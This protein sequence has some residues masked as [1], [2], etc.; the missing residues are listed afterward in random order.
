MCLF[1]GCKGTFFFLIYN[2]LVE[3]K[4]VLLSQ[5]DNAYGK[6]GLYD[7]KSYSCSY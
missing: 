7:Y 1:S 3:K 6:C 4:V 2:T 5:Q